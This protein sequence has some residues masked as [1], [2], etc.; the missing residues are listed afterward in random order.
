MAFRRFSKLRKNAGRRYKRR[1][2]R[3]PLRST[4]GRRSASSFAARVKN[5][6]QRSAEAKIVNYFYAQKELY[7]TTTASFNNGVQILTADTSGN[8]TYTIAQG[9]LQGQRGG[10]K[11][12]TKSAILKGSINVNPS[13]STGANYK[14][15][16]IFATLWIV[17]LKP[18]L[19][20]NVSTLASIVSNS[21]FQFGS[22][23]IGF[24]GTIVDM[25]K[26]PNHQQVTVLKKRVFKLGMAQYISATAVGTPDNT[27]QQ[28][29]NNDSAM[30]R[31]FTINMTKL[32]PK[33]LEF[34]DGTNV[35]NCRKIYMFWSACR[36]D[37]GI[38]EGTNP[39]PAYFNTGLEYRYT[40]Y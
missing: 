7:L 16:P 26:T 31:M 27:N 34:N 40:D 19:D 24:A 10:N 17:K 38:F 36:Q 3:R 29:A 5:V 37:G 35:A 39:V 32:Y 14:P 20:D 11:V 25:Q 9:S 1:T 30:V 12:N 18:Y 28:F 21:F 22:S 15:S 4:N 6:V 13:F 8:S 2:V 23:S 33:R